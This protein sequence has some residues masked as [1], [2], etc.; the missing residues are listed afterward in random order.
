[1]YH[2]MEAILNNFLKGPLGR[3]L[4]RFQQINSLTVRPRK[5]TALTQWINRRVGK[6]DRPELNIK[7]NDFMRTFGAISKLGW[8]C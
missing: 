4:N 1:M 2:R 8:G 3:H 5:V 6:A 7:E